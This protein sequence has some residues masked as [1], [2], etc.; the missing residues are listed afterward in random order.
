MTGLD[1]CTCVHKRAPVLDWT[2]LLLVPSGMLTRLD[3]EKSAL[4]GGGHSMNAAGLPR[5]LVRWMSN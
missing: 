4:N 1:S 5:S 3:I 2:R